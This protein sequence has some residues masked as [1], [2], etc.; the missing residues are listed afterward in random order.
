MS[1]EG[2]SKRN[3]DEVSTSDDSTTKKTKLPGTGNQNN[4]DP[5]TGNPST[6]NAVLPRPISNTGG[7][8]L[9]F[10][11]N[12]SLI[13]YGVAS[14][15]LT[16][17]GFTSERIGTTSLMY[18]P[19]DKPFFYLSPSEY[20]SIIAN[21]R[22]VR[23][24]EV[25]CKVIM[26]NP[27]TAFETNA[28]TS[29]LATLNQNKFI[30]Y[31]TGLINKTRGFNTVYKFE[32]GTNTMKPTK[33][34]TIDDPF[35]KKII[36]AMYGT[37][38]DDWTK[39]N[40]KDGATLPCSQMNLPMQF[41]CYYTLYANSAQHD[42]KLGWP[43]YNHMVTKCDASTVI[44]TT[45]LDYS[46]KPDIGFLSAPWTP[47][48]NGRNTTKG[49]N[50]NKF[51]VCN[52]NEMVIP[53]VMTINNSTTDTTVKKKINEYELFYDKQ[54]KV[55]FTDNFDRYTEPFEMSQY[56]KRGYGAAQGGKV[57]PSLHVGVCSV[58][59]LTTTNANFV[60]DKFTDIE[61]T[62]DIE[63]EIICEYGLPYHYSH[64]ATPHVDLE[65]SYMSIQNLTTA[66]TYWEN[67]SL[68]NNQFVLP[69]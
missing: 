67:L 13:S 47:V 51:T 15:Q 52:T 8:I 69:S 59:Q 43:L 58:P 31:S 66:D 62:W 38:P 41:P 46:Y 12:H 55:L 65:N 61:C 11:K 20:N 1:I 42:G 7:H 22:G 9:V 29:T 6:Q 37:D 35:M 44:G 3:Y 53:N 17:D 4:G 30:Q 45:V 5:D 18:L 26:R 48:H 33:V 64:F 34:E 23:V 24:K 10:K 14:V 32:S 63:T 19:V 39:P 16:L 57:Q 2:S 40:W 21:I 36:S 56:V 60:P 25:K 27:R 49:T 50:P 28:S 68:F 54:W